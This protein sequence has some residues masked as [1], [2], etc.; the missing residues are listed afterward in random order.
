MDD[1]T[2]H[3][4]P[5]EL[6]YKIASYLGNAFFLPHECVVEYY[7]HKLPPHFQTTAPLYLL[8]VKKVWNKVVEKGNT[9]YWEC[10]QGSVWKDNAWMSC[11]ELAEWF[12]VNKLKVTLEWTSVPYGYRDFL[13]Y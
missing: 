2:L 12:V 6:R 4:V 9:E 5:E 3:H 1:D 11:D 13:D 7:R 10:V 8:R